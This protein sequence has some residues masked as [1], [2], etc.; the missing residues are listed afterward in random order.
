MTRREGPG[1]LGAYR[2][3]IMAEFERLLA[4]ARRARAKGLDPFPEPEPGLAY[5]VASLVE[6]MTGP[7]GVAERIRELSAEMEKDELAFRIAEEIVAGRFGDL[8]GEEA[9]AARTRP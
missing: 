1:E 3:S 5:D 4:I 2:S 6:G 8:G 7:P 9:K